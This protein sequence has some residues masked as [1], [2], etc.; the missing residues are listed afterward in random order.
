MNQITSLVVKQKIN[1]GQTLPSISL[2]IDVP[3]KPDVIKVSNIIHI[4]PNNLYEVYLLSSDLISTLDNV[5]SPLT[6][7]LFNSE[8]TVFTNDKTIRGN[9]NFYFDTPLPEGVFTMTLTFIQN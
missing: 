4:D 6:S 7:N 9:Y 8:P 2:T 1:N 3:F 5:L